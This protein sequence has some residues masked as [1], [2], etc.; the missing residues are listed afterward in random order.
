MGK[1]GIRELLHKVVIKST[2]GD[3]GVTDNDVLSCFQL[4]VFMAFA[5]SLEHNHGPF[6]CPIGRCKKHHGHV[7]FI[8]SGAF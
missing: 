2:I 4:P 1:M 7:H 6:L 8:M 3:G 5:S